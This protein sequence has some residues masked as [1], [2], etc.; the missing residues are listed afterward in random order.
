MVIALTRVCFPSQAAARRYAAREL[1]PVF[2]GSEPLTAKVLEKWHERVTPIT[3]SD[4]A[5]HGD[6]HRGLRPRSA[7]QALHPTSSG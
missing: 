5:A 6:W 2:G 1:D 7:A 3:P 4:R